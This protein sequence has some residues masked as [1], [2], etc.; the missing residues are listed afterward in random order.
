[1]TVQKFCVYCAVLWRP[2][3]TKA[4]RNIAV[5]GNAYFERE[6]K[7]DFL[8]SSCSQNYKITHVNQITLMRAVALTQREAFVRPADE[9]TVVTMLLLERCT[10]VRTLSIPATFLKEHWLRGLLQ[11]RLCI[12]LATKVFEGWSTPTF[13]LTHPFNRILS[14]LCLSTRDQILPAQNSPGVCSSRFWGNSRTCTTPLRERAQSQ[15]LT[16]QYLHTVMNDHDFTRG[17]TP[18]CVR[19]KVGVL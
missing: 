17:L 16:W 7:D 12:N 2:I 11:D 10:R 19:Q 15:R 5:H 1:M 8:D 3:L 9:A 6:N 14:S 13:C 18:F 4:V